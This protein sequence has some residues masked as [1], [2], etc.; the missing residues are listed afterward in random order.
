MASE[1]ILLAQQLRSDFFAD[2]TRVLQKGENIDRR[3]R[4]RESGGNEKGDEREEGK[5]ETRMRLALAVRTNVRRLGLL[6]AW[7]CV[8]SK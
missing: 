5:E 8:G 6:K 3:I 2:W 7:V 1:A 4:D